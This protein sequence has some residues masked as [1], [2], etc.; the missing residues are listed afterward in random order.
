MLQEKGQG[1][2]RDQE[3]YWRVLTQIDQVQDSIARKAEQ[4][5]K[6]KN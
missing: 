4:E 3:D 1:A 6:A 5:A 2:D